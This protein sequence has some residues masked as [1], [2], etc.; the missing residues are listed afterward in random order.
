MEL[1]VDRS[2]LAKESLKIHSC[3]EENLRLLG[4]KCTS[5]ESTQDYFLGII[6]RQSILTMDLST[7]LEKSQGNNLTTPL[8]ICRC[9]IDDFLHL[10]YL[11]NNSNQEENIIRINAGEPTHYKLKYYGTNYY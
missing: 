9:L 10:F 1:P 3:T 8:V 4:G 2:F 6:R 7:I 11:I 5:K